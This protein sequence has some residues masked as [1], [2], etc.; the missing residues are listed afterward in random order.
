M[1]IK[2]VDT[3]LTNKDLSKAW[4]N[5]VE[6]HYGLVCDEVHTRF[7]TYCHSLEQS[8]ADDL[9]DW[10]AGKNKFNVASDTA[11]R[12]RQLAST[13]YKTVVAAHYAKHPWDKK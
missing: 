9:L 11:H 2:P 5:W 3:I 1:A 12:V 4:Y 10:D 8:H 7:F 6:A 13:H